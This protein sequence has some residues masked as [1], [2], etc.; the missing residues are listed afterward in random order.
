[1]LRV[2]RG[3]LTLA[4]LLAGLASETITRSVDAIACGRN[5][6]RAWASQKDNTQYRQQ[7]RSMRIYTRTGDKGTSSLY[8]GERRRKDD[9]VFAALGDVDELNSCVGLARAHIAGDE[10]LSTLA[11]QLELI[12]S[13]LMDVGSAV[14]TPLGSRAG[15]DYVAFDASGSE[16]ALLESQI[17]EM[18]TELPPLRN[19]ILPGGGHASA[20]LHLCRATCRRAERAAT[21]L[22]SAGG[23]EEGVTRFLNRLS[24]Y[25]F[26]AARLA[27]MKQGQPETVYKKAREV[28][29]AT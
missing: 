16:A 10:H 15:R 25:L 24:D 1:M 26:V 4:P 9:D 2:Q 22:V 5:T 8:S 19:F 7:K 13:R 28:E 21:K 12:Q 17:D 20:A 14:A 3:A 27:A 11:T 18:E 29:A 23:A 6:T